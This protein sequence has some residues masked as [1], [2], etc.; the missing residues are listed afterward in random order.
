MS[1]TTVQWAPCGSEKG[2]V[3]PPVPKRIWP[4]SPGDH[5]KVDDSEGSNRD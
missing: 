2:M 3:S 5:E 4:D 1:V